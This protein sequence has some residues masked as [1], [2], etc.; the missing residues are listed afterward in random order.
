MS[1]I[2]WDQERVSLLGTEHSIINANVA[3]VKENH[4]CLRSTEDLVL[5]ALTYVIVLQTPAATLLINGDAVEMQQGT[6]YRL[7][8]AEP[9]LVPLEPGSVVSL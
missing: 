7:D 6:A 4:H 8:I 3:L 2:V 1:V 9:A 5:D